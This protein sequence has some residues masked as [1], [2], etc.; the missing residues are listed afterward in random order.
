MH[1]LISEAGKSITQALTLS[2]RQ[3][4]QNT[5]INTLPLSSTHTVISASCCLPFQSHHTMHL[6]HTTVHRQRKL[7][8]HSLLLVSLRQQIS[9]PALQQLFQ[10]LHAFWSDSPQRLV[11]PEKKTQQITTI[12]MHYATIITSAFTRYTGWWYVSNILLRYNTVL[13]N[14]GISVF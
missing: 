2:L 13:Y 7:A 10:K 4:A 12:Y 11:C 8:S 3:L 5:H 14:H 9:L 6:P 1:T